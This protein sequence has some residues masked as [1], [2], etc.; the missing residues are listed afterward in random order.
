MYIR[1]NLKHRGTETKIS[2]T[3]REFLYFCKKKHKLNFHEQ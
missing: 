2:T 1:Y 3:I